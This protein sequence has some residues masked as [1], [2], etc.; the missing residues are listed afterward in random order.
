MKGLGT[1][2]EAG[3]RPVL[4]SWYMRG[5]GEKPLMPAAAT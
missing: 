5:A 2:T 4:G 3:V 1:N